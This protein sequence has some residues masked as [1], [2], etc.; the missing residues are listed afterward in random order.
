MATA[1]ARLPLPDFA[2]PFAGRRTMSAPRPGRRLE[3]GA[4]SDAEAVELIARI[5]RDAD[6]AAFA[7]LFRMF[8]P[9]L[10]AFLMRSGSDPATAE[11]IAQE[12]MVAVWRN[13][14]S[15]DRARASAATWIFTI[16][17][18]RRIDLARRDGRSR[19]DPQ[20]YE[21][22]MAEPPEPADRRAIAQ[23]TGQ[24]MQ[25]LVARLAPEQVALIR[26]AFFEDKSHTTIAAEL[27]LP[28]GT[29]KSRI[30]MALGLLRAAL[31]GES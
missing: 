19:I 1:L 23:Q 31:Q 9:R 26:M 17:R 10:K 2:L 22:L 6:K 5:A 8:A 20:E 21:L 25:D 29:V 27:G 4:C 7:D 13:A 28:L 18:N 11:E 24:R 30:R 14:A 15:F 3:A 12:T 16:A